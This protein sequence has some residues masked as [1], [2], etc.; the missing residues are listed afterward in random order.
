MARKRDKRNWK[1]LEWMTEEKEREKR[2]NN[3]IIVG[4]DVRKRYVSDDIVEWLRKEIEVGVKIEKVWRVRILSGKFLPG[5]QCGSE[6]DK[7]EVMVN[8]K[9]LGDKEVYI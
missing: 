7:K 1:G 2:K 9:K 8:K 4:L 6:K 3:L 5:A